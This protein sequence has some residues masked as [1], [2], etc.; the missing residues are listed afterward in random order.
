MSGINRR[1]LGNGLGARART[2]FYAIALVSLL[3]VILLWDSDWFERFY[4]FTRKYEFY[5]LDDLSIVFVILSIGG[6][7]FSVSRYMELRVEY[8]KRIEAEQRMEALALTDALTGL[9]NRRHFLK[10][11]DECVEE[12]VRHGLDFALILFDLDRFKPVND[13]HGHAVGDQ[14]LQSLAERI[15][16]QMRGVDLL[17][18]LGGDE[19]AIIL[20]HTGADDEVSPVADRVLMAVEA[21]FLIGAVSCQIGV[22]LGIAVSH[23][24]TQIH[25]PLTA[26]ELMQ[27]AD[28]ALYRAKADGRGRYH[29]FEPAM[30]EKIRERAVME[31]ELKEAV[32]AQEIRAY[33]Q[34]LVCLTDGRIEGYEVLARWHHPMRGVVR[35]DQFIQV[36]EDVGLIGK[37]TLSLLEQAC[38]ASRQWPEGT[39]ISIN[40]SPVQLRD[41]SLCAAFMKV[42]QAYGVAPQNLELEITENALFNDIETARAVLTEFKALGMRLA[43]DDFGTGYSSL[44]HLRLLP[45][46]KLKIDKTFVMNMH[47]NAESLKIIHAII[48][49]SRSLGLRITAEGIETKA[50]ATWLVEAGCHTGQGYYY[51]KPAPVAKI[52]V[53]DKVAS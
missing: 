12:Q 6:I 43:L 27:R 44:Q 35:P 41:P 45:F 36:V 15:Q 32:L 26:V 4:F 14:L 29:F 7:F 42:L 53:F 5:K 8:A 33:Y 49:L 18:R 22:S 10:R 21:P 28:L 39:Y 47:D 19:F 24:N 48:A 37:M 40:I 23:Q 52:A 30:D 50:N 20:K 1:F 17:A 3:L 31:F 2:E 9:A 46:D 38:K 16:G 51:G 11:L 13:F 25:A 34:P